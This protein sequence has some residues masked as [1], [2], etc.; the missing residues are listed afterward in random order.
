MTDEEIKAAAE[1]Y[2]ISVHNQVVFTAGANFACG[3]MKVALA[4]ET[5]MHADWKK[6]AQDHGIELIALREQLKVAKE[7]IEHFGNK[8][9]DPVAAEA[10][11]RLKSLE[12]QKDINE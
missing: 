6:M 8:Y 10:L 4:N 5:Q 2:S 7:A 1:K 11:S 12:T 3:E 9:M